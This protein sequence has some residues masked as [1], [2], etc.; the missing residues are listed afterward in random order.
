MADALTIVY[1]LAVLLAAVVGVAGVVY[2]TRETSEADLTRL[3]L[4]G[5]G[6]LLFVVALVV[7]MIQ[8]GG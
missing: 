1:S 5:A 8:L 7:T 4:T 6:I 2:T 3:G